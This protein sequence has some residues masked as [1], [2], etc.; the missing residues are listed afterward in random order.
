MCRRNFYQVAKLAK[1]L[2]MKISSYTSIQH[3]VYKMNCNHVTYMKTE[4]GITH[5]ILLRELLTITSIM[6]ERI[7]IINM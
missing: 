1:F 3:K 5:R 7:G 6:H 2:L 4:R